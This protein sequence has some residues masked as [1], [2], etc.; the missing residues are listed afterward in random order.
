[1]ASRSFM[2]SSILPLAIGLA[3]AACSPGAS[4]TAPSSAP[5]TAAATNS[6]ETA[7]P[8]DAST[9]G[10]GESKV[11]LGVVSPSALNWIDFTALHQ[12]FWEGEG[13][14][15]DIIFTRAAATSAQQVASGDIQLASAGLDPSLRA[16]EAGSDMVL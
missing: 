10:P 11:T 3:L 4:T 14:T 16:I 1:L 8:T 5:P 13:L 6:E 2:R 12:G 7:A 9:P 15:V